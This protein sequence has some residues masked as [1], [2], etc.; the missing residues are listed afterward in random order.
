[1]DYLDKVLE[2][3][4]EWARR[5]VEAL[6]GPEPEPEPELIPIPVDNP[7]RHVR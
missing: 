4:K 7:R 6:F 5:L 2:Q 3:L 1:M